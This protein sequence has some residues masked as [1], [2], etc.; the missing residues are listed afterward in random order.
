VPKVVRKISKRTD[1]L[2]SC[3]DVKLLMW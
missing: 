2:I 1:A 3:L